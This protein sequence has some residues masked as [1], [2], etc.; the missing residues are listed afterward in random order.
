M[1]I[2]VDDGGS[3]WRILISINPGIDFFPAPPIPQERRLV[4]AHKL[5][6]A[7]LSSRNSCVLVLRLASTGE[8]PPMRML[9]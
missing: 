3:R 4:E 7:R 8:E 1:L 9:L 5:T 2:S 6:E